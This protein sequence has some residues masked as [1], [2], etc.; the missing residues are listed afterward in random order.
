M[1]FFSNT[2]C[3]C[4]RR[5]RSTTPS[6][7]AFTDLRLARFSASCERGTGGAALRASLAFRRAVCG[8]LK[9]RRCLLSGD[10]V[11]RGIAPAVF[12]Q[13]ALERRAVS[14]SCAGL[15]KAGAETAPLQKWESHRLAFLFDSPL[16]ARRSPLTI[17]K[18]HM[19]LFYCQGA[20]AS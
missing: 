1:I 9:K 11:G 2:K 14:I 6:S 12:H 10:I 5:R 16:S 4:R 7:C 3:P 8:V 20:S 13:A 15:F 19:A 18:S 17:K